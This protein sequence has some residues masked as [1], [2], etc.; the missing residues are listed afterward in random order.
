MSIILSAV[1]PPGDRN[2]LHT[3]ADALV[4]DF[5]L[6]QMIVASVS[7]KKV[8]TTAHRD[9]RNVVATAR[10]L[11]I[12][13]FPHGTEGWFKLREILDRQHEDRTGEVPLPWGGDPA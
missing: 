1:L 8:T 12:E 13:A 7:C 5:S 10:I 6:G 11:Q 2:G 9:S 4:D 3:I